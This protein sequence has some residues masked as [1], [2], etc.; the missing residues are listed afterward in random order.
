MH[1]FRIA[2]VTMLKGK[3]ILSTLCLVTMLGLTAAVEIPEITML[4]MRQATQQR[5]MT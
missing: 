2:E 1:L 5:K 4:L 3:V